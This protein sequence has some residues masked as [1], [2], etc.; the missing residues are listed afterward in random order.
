MKIIAANNHCILT[1]FQ[2]SL[3]GFYVCVITNIINR[4]ILE[5]SE[6][7]RPLTN[8]RAGPR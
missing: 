7:Q 5:G 3:L 8:Y 4:A 6:A 1:E 2:A